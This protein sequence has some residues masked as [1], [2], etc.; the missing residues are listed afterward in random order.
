MH[1]AHD[2]MHV[3][4]GE[5]DL[6]LSSSGGLDICR[7]WTHIYCM[8]CDSLLLLFTGRDL[9]F[10]LLDHCQHLKSP[11]GG[12]TCGSAGQLSPFSEFKDLQSLSLEY[13]YSVGVVL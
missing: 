6:C 10:I 11:T 2:W 4:R 1:D 8:M 7:P 13:I 9:F 3:C 12:S 5:A